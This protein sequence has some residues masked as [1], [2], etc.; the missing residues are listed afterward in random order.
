MANRHVFICFYCSSLE[1]ADIVLI[2]PSL[3]M[4]EL[5]KGHQETLKHSIYEQESRDKRTMISYA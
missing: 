5:K 1:R 2:V 4:T 3:K